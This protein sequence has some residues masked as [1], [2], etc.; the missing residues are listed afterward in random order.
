MTFLP[1]FSKKHKPIL[2]DYRCPDYLNP[3]EILVG[4][5]CR[6]KTEELHQQKNK[7]DFSSY[8][9]RHETVVA[10]LKEL[11]HNKCAYCESCFGA[12][13]AIRIDHYRPKDG[14]KGEKHTGYYWLGYEWSNLLPACEKCNGAKSNHFPIAGNR[15]HTKQD[16]PNEFVVTS[17]TFRA[18]SPL[19]INPEL[20]RPERQLMFAPDGSIAGTTDEGKKTIEVCGLDRETLV[21][22]RKKR[23]DRFKKKLRKAVRDYIDGK[24]NKDIFKYELKAIFSRALKAATSPKAPYIRLNQFLFRFFEPFFID[25]LGPKAREVVRRAFH[26]FMANKL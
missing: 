1:T 4:E 14:I 8:Y 25:P 16:D 23:A 19:I 21:L 13:G 6:L 26:L 22:E 5:S 7:H 9:Y 3:P 11:Y 20:D 17:A 18:E 15:V 2:H 12:T 24:N 10:Y